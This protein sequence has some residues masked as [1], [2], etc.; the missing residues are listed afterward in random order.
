MATGAL[1]WPAMGPTEPAALAEARRRRVVMRFGGFEL[2]AVRFELRREG[3]AV[4]L[5]PQPYDL[6]WLLAA[7]RGEVVTRE[8]IR[9]ALW[10]EG[11]FVAFDGCVNFAVR[12]LRKV[13]GDDARQPRFIE[14]LRGRGYR[15]LAAVEV[16]EP[17]S[18][19][20]PAR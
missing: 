19:D 4:P 3:Q 12:E 11:T 20:G 7:G 8:E 10:G 9:R 17:D 1:D 5:P 15:F 18:V 13:L 16:L 6:L 14:A 2:D